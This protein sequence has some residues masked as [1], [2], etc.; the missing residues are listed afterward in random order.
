MPPFRHGHEPEVPGP[1]SDPR[2]RALR[3]AALGGDA[4]AALEL[5]DLLATRGD[6][7]GAEDTYAQAERAG[8]PTGAAMLGAIREARGEQAAAFEAY[9]R[10]DRAGD[11]LGAF[12]LGMAFSRAGD[13]NQ[14][15]S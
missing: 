10:A 8:N 15:R 11:A 13:W 9:A 4:Q 12:K 2:E 7:S 6:L 5:G 14:A 3:D 1:A